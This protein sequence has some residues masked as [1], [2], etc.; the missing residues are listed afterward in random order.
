MDWHPIITA[1]WE[2]A[3]ELAVIKPNGEIHTLKFPCQRTFSGWLNC[4]TRKWVDM[5]P[6]HWRDWQDG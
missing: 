4:K 1:P 6:T 5:R 2:R 3:V